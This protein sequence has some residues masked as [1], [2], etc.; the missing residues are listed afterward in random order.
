MESVLKVIAG[1]LDNPV[2]AA[3]VLLLIAFMF[4]F[5]SDVPKWINRLFSLKSKITIKSLNDHDIFNTCIRVKNE[6]SLMKF[7][8]HGSYDI[9]K[10]MMC[11]DFAKYKIDVCSKA[12]EDILNTNVEEMNPDKFKR[13][14]LNAQMDMHTNYINL[15]TKDWRN[16]KISEDDISYVV[17]LF[18]T[19]RYDVVAAFEHRINSIFGSSSH[20]NNTRRLLAIF[21][22]WA[23]GIDILP[24]DMQTTFETLNGKFKE[25]KY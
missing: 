16:R 11:K 4:I 25:I 24:R 8:T 10:S 18:E 6:I 5:K 2:L 19:F 22:M 20:G 15:I 12:F 23:F 13:Y 3:V 9:T 17:N 14:I 7:Y 21:E 1:N